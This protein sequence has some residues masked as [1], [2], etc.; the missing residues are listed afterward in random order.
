MASFGRVSEI[1]LLPEKTNTEGGLPAQI[2]L[3]TEST[4]LRVLRHLV[5]GELWLKTGNFAAGR[6][7][8]EKTCETPRF[9]VEKTHA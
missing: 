2:N 6:R 3:R 4:R 8:R 7:L 5:S 9:M 1:D